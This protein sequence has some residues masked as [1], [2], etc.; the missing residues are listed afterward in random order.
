MDSA[1][2]VSSWLTPPGMDDVKIDRAMVSALFAND[3]TTHQPTAALCHVHK[4]GSSLLS[5]AWRDLT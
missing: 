4:R 2:G 5:L 1:N 3:I